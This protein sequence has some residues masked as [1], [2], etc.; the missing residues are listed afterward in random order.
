MGGTAKHSTGY[1]RTYL[2]LRIRVTRG[3]SHNYLETT[4][5]NRDRKTR[6]RKDNVYLYEIVMV[7]LSPRFFSVL[8]FSFPLCFVYE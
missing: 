7:A 2:L 3:Y 5:K 6:G 8:E 4:T 1:V